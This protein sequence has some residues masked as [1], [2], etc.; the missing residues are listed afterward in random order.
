MK[1]FVI[2]PDKVENRGAIAEALRA[3]GHDLLNEVCSLTGVVDKLHAQQP[4][5]EVVLVR[6]D[7]VQRER[8]GELLNLLAEWPVVVLVPPGRRGRSEA[9]EVLRQSTAPHVRGIISV[10]PFDFSRLNEWCATPAGSAGAQPPVVEDAPSTLTAAV[11][12]PAASPATSAAP[13][14]IRRQVR[15]GFYGVRGGVGVSTTAL[16][17]AQALAAHGQRVVLFDATGRGDLHVMLGREPEPQ[18]TI[19]SL[20]VLLGAPNEE[21]V[22]NFDAIVIDGGR[23]AGNFNAQWVELRKPGNEQAIARWA[24]VIE[25]SAPRALSLG[26]LVSIEVTD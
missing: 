21:T 17:V 19:G 9:L 12:S 8:E 13:A 24:G 25:S 14:A 20:T 3:S 22:Q 11:V 5:P 15:L 18:T 23:Q 10:P 7:I 2:G 6:A 1:V 16:K 4:K 26:R